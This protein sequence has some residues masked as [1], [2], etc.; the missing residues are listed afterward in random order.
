M[1]AEKQLRIRLDTFD[2]VKGMLMILLI[3]GHKIPYYGDRLPDF[4]K[5]IE[6][7]MGFLRYGTNPAFFMIAGFGFRA[8]NGKKCLSKTFGDLVKPYLYVMAAYAVCFPLLHY[9]VFRWWPGAIHEA[10]RFLLAFLLGLPRSGKV[11]LGYELYECSV[12]WFLLSLFISLNVLNWILNRKGEKLQ[13]ILVLVC[14]AVGYLLMKADFIYY[15]IPQGLI[16][17]GCC[18]AGFLIKKK[19][20]Y[21]S[22]RLPVICIALVAATVVQLIWGGFSM[23]GGTSVLGVF[24]LIL[25]GCTGALVLFMGIWIGNLEWRALDPIKTIGVYTYW[26][27]CIHSVDMSC[28]PWYQWSNYMSSRPL[29]GLAIEITIS[30]LIMTIGCVVLKK[31]AKWRHKRRSLANG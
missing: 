21:N 29:L 13:H 2:F 17:V 19:K 9:A 24:D 20:L 8:T 7:V 4:I 27:I 16:G 3:W 6:P 10:I 12:V 5:A 1:K 14:F 31:I 26:L 23:A 15:C 30:G 28:I 11:F 25:S 18:Y 22:K